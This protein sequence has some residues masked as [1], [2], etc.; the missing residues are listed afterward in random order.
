MKIGRNE[1]C[2]CGS[3]LKYKNCCLKIE[4]IKMA[5]NTN[6][7]EEGCL[8]AV[9]HGFTEEYDNLKA[10]EIDFE[11]SC[12]LVIKADAEIAK[13]QNKMMQFDLLKAGDWFAI[14]EVNGELKASYRYDTADEAM[15]IAGEK[16]NAT[17]F[18]SMPEPI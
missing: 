5:R 9:F 10:F 7:T 1:T 3:K 12:C 4:T 6:V 16:F 17:R 15:E 11:K 14:A 13:Q 8:P 18:L 2:P